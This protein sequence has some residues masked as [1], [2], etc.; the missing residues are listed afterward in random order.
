[1]DF[2]SACEFLESL[3]SWERDR[4]S[5]YDF[6]LER[7]RSVV[8]GAGVDFSGLRIVHVA[9][10][11]GKGT[12]CHLISELLKREGKTV[13]LFTSPHL[14][15]V[16]ERIRVNGEMISR[17]RFGE[18]VGEV[19]GLE[20]TYFE[21]LTLVALKYFVDE[22]VEFAVLEVGL[23]GRLDSTNIVTPELTILTAVEMEHVGVLGESLSEILD[24]KLG[25]VKEGVPLLVGDQSEEV[26]G[27]LKEKLKRKVDVYFV[28][29]GD[30]ARAKNEKL[31]MCAVSII[32]ND[33]LKFTQNVN[34]RNFLIEGRFDVREIDG[35]TVVFDVAHTVGSMKNLVETL[36]KRF[37]DK[38]F[39][40]LV[41]FLPDKDREG[42]MKVIDEVAEDVYEGVGIEEIDLKKD[43][44]LVVTGS[45]SLVGKFIP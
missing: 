35:K 43:Q 42:M 22:G 10:S 27:L 34:I 6:D 5:E 20:V 24:E 4:N 30:D 44:V 9:G 28:N 2:E 26:M 37:P 13:G 33:T 21:A 18:Y 15:D 11:K 14:R 7:F 8:S 19:V 39:V 12:V 17:E 38:E 3:D 16:R 45:H 36:K 25:I 23:G 31:A 29:G 1:M 41:K 32:S 40:F